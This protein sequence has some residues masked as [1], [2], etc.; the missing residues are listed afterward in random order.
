MKTSKIILS[1]LFFTMSFICTNAQLKVDNI[2]RVFMGSYPSAYT[3]DYHGVLTGQI[4]GSNGPYF[5]NSKL[6]FGDFGMQE[7][8]SWNV[9]IGEYGTTDTDQ[10]WLHGKNGQEIDTKRMILTK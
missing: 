3:G 10:L 8:N 2:G 1:V 4:F 9:F 7:Y 6:A 5:A